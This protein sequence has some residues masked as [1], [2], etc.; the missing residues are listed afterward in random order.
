MPSL[1]RLR[2]IFDGGTE[3][4]AGGC[5]WN[6]LF[7]AGAFGLVRIDEGDSCL[8]L[9]VKQ[10]VCVAYEGDAVPN[11]RWLQAASLPRLA[12]L[13]GTAPAGLH[14]RGKG[15]DTPRRVAVVGTRKA[16]PGAIRFAYELGAAVARSGA[17]LVSGGALG[18]DIAA[19]RGALDAR[20]VSWAVLAT[21]V[22]RPAP[23]RHARDF[24][25][26]CERG[27]LL[28]EYD[29]RDTAPWRYLARNRII[30]A[31]SD[32]VVVVQAP[33][34]SGALS[35]ARAAEGLGR[36]VWYVPS[37]PWNHRGRGGLLAMARGRPL[38]GPA[39][40]A[41]SETPQN[42]LSLQN[43]ALNDAA[44]Y[45]RFDDASQH[46]TLGDSRRSDVEQ[47]GEA[48]LPKGA[49]ARASRSL[50]YSRP[51]CEDLDPR[52]RSVFDALS[53]V[54]TYADDL[55]LHTRVS[56]SEVQCILLTLTLRGLV[57]ETSSGAYVRT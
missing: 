51:G 28:S 37:S 47:P 17:V 40:L 50:V 9:R 44:Q 1:A 54:P 55:A 36:R 30:A 41:L 10:S 52:A 11:D 34:R 15:E 33:I 25:R 35:T 57:E 23:T 4:P 26:L 12:D 29:D 53:T 3:Q 14:A 48:P 32:D 6:A 19:H 18:I 39:D 16:D 49:R 13:A 27:Q 7:P 42:G 45:G 38:Y 43:A 22:H 2:H 20:G 24:E 56:A 31:L 8:R 46:V 21:G 5:S